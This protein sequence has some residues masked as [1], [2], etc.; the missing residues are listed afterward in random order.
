VAG[1]TAERTN[2]LR[3]PMTNAS[4]PRVPD[5][6]LSAEVMQFLRAHIHSLEQLEI[7]TLLRGEPA[8]DWTAAEIYERLLSNERSI[9]GRLGLFAER[10]LV[11]VI[12][13]GRY[14]YA[15]RD[16]TVDSAIEATLQAY[17]Q[18]RVVVI[19]TIFRPEQDPAKSF[20]DAF[21]FKQP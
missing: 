12:D 8:R 2:L 21:R 11:R 6:S 14:R 10:G 19:E 9:E 15:P 20:A 16:A 13:G 5:E 1:C 4:C 7:L 18:R 3:P 17:K